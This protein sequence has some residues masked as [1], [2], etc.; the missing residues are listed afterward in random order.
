MP[1]QRSLSCATHQ[2]HYWPLSCCP[3]PLSLSNT[4]SVTPQMSLPSSHFSA[5]TVCHTATAPHPLHIAGGSATICYNWCISPNFPREHGVPI[6]HPCIWTSESQVVERCVKGKNHHTF[7]WQSASHGACSA[8][9]SRAPLIPLCLQNKL[10]SKNLLS[11]AS[12]R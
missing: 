3:S 7:C 8:S 5:M 9:C 12:F 2:P 1:N 11:M 10:H 6:W 4:P